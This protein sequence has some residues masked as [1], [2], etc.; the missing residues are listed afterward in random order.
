MEVLI[1][2]GIDETI[3]DDLMCLYLFTEPKLTSFLKKNKSEPMRNSSTDNKGIQPLSSQS[4][5]NGK[6]EETPK[7]AQ[8]LD[9]PNVY[10]HEN[11]VDSLD[12]E[13]SDK[14][15]TECKE[16]MDNSENLLD[17]QDINNFSDS[18]LFSEKNL[19]LNAD[20]DK[21]KISCGELK[22][23]ETEISFHTQVTGTDSEENASKSAFAKF[24]QAASLPPSSN[25]KK[26]HSAT[27]EFLSN[28]I[29]KK[30]Q[31]NRETNFDGHENEIK[32]ESSQNAEDKDLEIIFEAS[33]KKD[34]KDIESFKGKISNGEH[35]SRI[36]M[37][38]E[39]DG[40]EFTNRK[41]K[42][43][44]FNIETLRE[45]IMSSQAKDTHRKIT[46]RFHAKISPT[47][48]N[49][50]E[51]ELRKEISKDMFLKVWILYRTL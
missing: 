20:N 27:D 23:S 41:L 39:Y 17:T 42:E 25:C 29:A 18:N 28:L 38:E 48:N 50:A 37:C 31:I 51:D 49:A 16:A 32:I 15:P 26:V 8:D 40:S 46:R 47:D 19:L 12:V 22:S 33:S 10:G 13:I 7:E 45:R 44:D 9:K 3:Y 24:S 35:S 6:T 2:S 5:I 36:V 4:V 21:C 30:S 11:C 14:L 1:F 34:T 43:V